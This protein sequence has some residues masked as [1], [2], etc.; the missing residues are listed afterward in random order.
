MR[1]VSPPQPRKYTATLSRFH[2]TRLP[3]AINT[4]SDEL[5]RKRSAIK[6]WCEAGQM[7]VLSPPACGHFDTL[8]TPAF[9]R[10]NQV[11]L[12]T[13]EGAGPSKVKE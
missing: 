1:V 7:S 11:M 4:A 10:S 13:V 8:W 3:E 2:P 9:L 5:T 12:R 6:A